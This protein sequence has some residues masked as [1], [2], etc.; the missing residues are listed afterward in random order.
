MG[1]ELLL[2]IDVCLLQWDASVFLGDQ[3]LILS[4]HLKLHCAHEILKLGNLM[5]KFLVVSPKIIHLLWTKLVMLLCVTVVRESL[6]LQVRRGLKLNWAYWPREI[7]FRYRTLWRR[8]LALLLLV[9][10]SLD[11]GCVSLLEVLLSLWGFMKLHGEKLN[12]LLKHCLLLMELRLLFPQLLH[13]IAYLVL[14]L[15]FTSNRVKLIE[16]IKWLRHQPRSCKS[17][18]P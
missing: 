14:L 2:Q 11:H 9:L 3:Q 4:P 1:F 6:L 7:R 13:K 12:L 15:L 18:T 16:S 8:A 10:Q 5:V 17:G